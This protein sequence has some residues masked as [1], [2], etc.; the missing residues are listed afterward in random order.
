MTRLC[1]V[2]GFHNFVGGKDN[3][4]IFKEGIVYSVQSILGTII[5]TP[6]GEGHMPADQTKHNLTEIILDGGYLLTQEEVETIK[7]KE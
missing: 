1:K 3:D 6:I 7:E 5:L 4:N 2:K